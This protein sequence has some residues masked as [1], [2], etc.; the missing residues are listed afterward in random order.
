M[1][2]TSNKPETEF[3]LDF[4]AMIASCERRVFRF[5]LA[6]SRDV[7]LARTLTRKTFSRARSQKKTFRGDLPPAVWMMRLALDVTP[8]ALGDPMLKPMTWRAKAKCL[9][10]SLKR[11]TNSQSLSFVDAQVLKIWEA[12]AGL[13]SHLRSILILRVVEEIE[14]SQISIITGLPLEQVH[15]HLHSAM[16]IVERVVEVPVGQRGL[17]LENSSPTM[18]VSS[19]RRE[20]IRQLG[21]E[22]TN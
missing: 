19:T 21:P 20:P 7:R 13:P 5:H 16:V 18:S 3:L 8:E 22:N 6:S 9:I 2:R 12:V 1:R 17:K 14:P 11:T 15:S 10:R 4:D